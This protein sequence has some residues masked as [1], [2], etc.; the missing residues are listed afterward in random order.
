MEANRSAI[1]AQVYA[2]GTLRNAEV[3]ESMGMLRDIHARWLKKQREFLGL[4]AKA[5]DNAGGFQAISK[6]LQTTAGACCCWAW[7]PG[8]CWTTSA[9]ESDDDHGVGAG[10]AHAGAA[11]T[12]GNAVAG[13]G[14]C[15]RCL[16]PR[17]HL[18]YSR[19]RRVPS[20][21]PLPPPWVT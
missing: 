1:G 18:C 2:D 10:G 21:M 19:C 7:G 12:G 4:Q 16:E 20:S 8:C 6:F 17:R 13:R 9:G 14:E 5:S 3:I 11:G 15:A